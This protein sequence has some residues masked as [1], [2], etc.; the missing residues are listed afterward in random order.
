MPNNIVP[1][2]LEHLSNNQSNQDI[3]K[4]IN[5]FESRKPIEESLLV[6]IENREINTIQAEIVKICSKVLNQKEIDIYS[7]FYDLGADSLLIARITTKIINH[8]DSSIPFEKL[9]REIIKNPT[10]Y[11]I[12]KQLE[13]L[14]R[15]MIRNDERTH[16]NK[17]PFFKSKR[18]RCANSSG[19]MRIIVSGVS[20]FGTNLDILASK[21]AEQSLGDIVL[22]EILDKEQFLEMTYKTM[23]EKLS[24]LYFDEIEKYNPNVVQIIG[25]SFGGMIALE[26]AKRCLESGI[27]VVN[28]SMIESGIIPKNDY[29]DIYLEMIFMQSYGLHV[30]GINSQMKNIK[31]KQPLGKYSRLKTLQRSKD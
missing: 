23:I 21:L 20:N 25:H 6:N 9:L 26:L 19:I 28:L 2:E 13:L 10:V 29:N 17:K 14:K 4:I 27:D 15:S 12:S 16:F 7:N 11:E 31:E 1:I 5:S 18:Y 22:L 8:I 3:Q 24:Y 30:E